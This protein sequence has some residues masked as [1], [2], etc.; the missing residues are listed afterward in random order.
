MKKFIFEKNNKSHKKLSDFKI[1]S[2]NS[3]KREELKTKVDNK[4]K[5]IGSLGILEDLAIKIGLIQDTLSPHLENPTVIVFAGDHGIVNEGVSKY[6]QEVTHQMVQ[7][8]VNGGAAIS[9]LTSQNNMKLF[10]VDAGVNYNFN[11]VLGLIDAKV[12]Y[13]TKNCLHS[14]AMTNNEVVI[15]ISYGSQIIDKL[16]EGGCNIVGI[17]EMGIGNTSSASLIMSFLCKLSIDQCVGKGTGLNNEGVLHKISVL[18][19]V[20]DFHSPLLEISNSQLILQTFGGFEIAMMAGAILRAAELKMTILIDGFISS[21]A[22]LVAYFSHQSVLD[23][24]IFSHVSD[25]LGHQSL[26]E[27]LG[28]EALVNLKLRLGEGTGAAIA[29]P[30]IKSSIEILNKMATFENAGVSKSNN[31]L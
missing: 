25:E 9:V 28:A 19:K 11:A 16:H 24:C 20:I 23:Y 5:P 3:N 1:A 31:E 17:G 10:V 30:I 8:F 26:L 14:K 13:G 12:G 18:N 15:S 22:L 7:N 6:P 27:F 2:L 4:T 29:Y 21:S